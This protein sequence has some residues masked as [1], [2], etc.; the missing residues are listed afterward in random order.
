MK[1]STCVMWHGKHHYVASEANCVIHEDT[2]T[3]SMQ[4]WSSE[5]THRLCYKTRYSL[6]MF[7]GGGFWWLCAVGC[8]WA[9]LGQGQRMAGHTKSGKPMHE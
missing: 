9:G 5:C 1:V 2:K 8:G 4:R 7:V 3:A 6:C